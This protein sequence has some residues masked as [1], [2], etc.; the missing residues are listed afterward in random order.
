MG[1]ARTSTEAMG[2][3]SGAIGGARPCAGV[4]GGARTSTE[5]IGGASGAM[6]GPWRLGL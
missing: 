4:M 5:A 2:G 6:G 1:G 3:A